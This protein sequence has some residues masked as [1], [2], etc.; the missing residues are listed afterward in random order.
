M[1]LHNLTT[2]CNFNLQIDGNTASSQ[3]NFV[4]I[5]VYCCAFSNTVSH[6]KGQI[7]TYWLK[8]VSE[9]EQVHD[10]ELN[11]VLEARTFLY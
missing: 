9:N 2:K 5:I 7:A 11:L 10:G 1:M 6:T 3:S 4:Q 8:M